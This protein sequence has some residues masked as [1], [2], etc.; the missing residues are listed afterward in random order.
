MS[1]GCLSMKIQHIYYTLV[2]KKNKSYISKNKAIYKKYL[3]IPELQELSSCPEQ[4][5]RFWE[6]DRIENLLFEC[7]D[8]SRRKFSFIPRD[9][10]NTEKSRGIKMKFRLSGDLGKPLKNF[11]FSDL[12]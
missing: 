4:N 5:L 12:A 3:I 10:S 8:G 6:S 9:I 2:F 11:T 7:S 1:F